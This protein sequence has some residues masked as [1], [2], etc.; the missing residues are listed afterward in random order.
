MRNDIPITGSELSNSLKPVA[1]VTRIKEKIK[2][3]DKSS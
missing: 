3:K 1:L 2:E